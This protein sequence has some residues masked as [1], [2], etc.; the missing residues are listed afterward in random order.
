[1]S[2]LN[3]TNSTGVSLNPFSVLNGAAKSWVCVALL[4]QW[5]FAVYILSL[6]AIPLITGLTEQSAAAS[7]AS[8]HTKDAKV[9]FS[10]VLPAVILATSGLLQLIPTVR[11]H[12]PRFHR[13]NGR[14]FFI[15]GISGALTGLY[16]TWV[17]GLRLS[18]VGAIGITLNGILIPIAIFFAWR[19]A[20]QKNI[21]THQR[22]AVHSFFLV[23]GVWTFRL[24][25]FGWYM[26]NQGFNGNTTTLDGPVDIFISFACYLLPMTLAELYFWAKRQTKASAPVWIIAVM[27]SLGFVITAIGVCATAVMMWWPRI[28]AVF[29]S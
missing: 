10:H 13:Y 21:A 26:V 18:D 15:L 12:F 11:K 20:I 28:S 17:T 25:L 3:L 2:S 8:G 19:T 9:F 4:G 29:F 1:M 16:L 24:Y 22:Y 5:M 27:M 23:N 7:P 14:V 6:Y